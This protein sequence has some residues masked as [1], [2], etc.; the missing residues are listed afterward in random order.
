L[1]KT[2]CTNVDGY[3]CFPKPYNVKILKAEVSPNHTSHRIPSMG[4]ESG[5]DMDLNIDYIYN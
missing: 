5:I 3:E 4:P 2:V 1:H